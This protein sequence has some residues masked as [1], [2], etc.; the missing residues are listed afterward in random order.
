MLNFMTRV[1]KQQLPESFILIWIWINPQIA[2]DF[3]LAFCLKLVLLLK[4]FLFY[5]SAF[6]LEYLS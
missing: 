6:I 3:S 5:Y 2:G 4:L 1:E